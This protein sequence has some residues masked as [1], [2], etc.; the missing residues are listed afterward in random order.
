MLTTFKKDTLIGYHECVK[1]ERY[2]DWRPKQEE[3]TTVKVDTVT[4]DTILDGK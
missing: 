3:E 1:S 2:G 4:A